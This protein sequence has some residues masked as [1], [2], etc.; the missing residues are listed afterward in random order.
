MDAN[1]AEALF[2]TSYPQG[3]VRPSSSRL[4]SLFEE[5]QFLPL[6]I[7]Q[8][9]SFIHRSPAPHQLSISDYLVYLRNT[10]L[11][12][13]N[14]EHIDNPSRAITDQNTDIVLSTLQI[15]F[16]QIEEQ[17]PLAGLF[18]VLWPA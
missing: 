1:E 7:K 17:S 9:A 18:S 14:T 2:R 15:T 3:F 12:M 10:K 4:L 13:S 5:V 11:I 8:A 16:D 6:A